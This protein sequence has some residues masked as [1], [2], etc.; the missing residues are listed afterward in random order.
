MLRVEIYD[1]ANSLSLKPEGRFTGDDAENIRTLITT[2][3]KT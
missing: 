1:S 2:S 3:I